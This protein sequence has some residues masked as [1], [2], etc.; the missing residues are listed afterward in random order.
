[1][2]DNQLCKRLGNLKWEFTDLGN[3]YLGSKVDV[4]MCVCVCESVYESVGQMVVQGYSAIFSVMIV[5]LALK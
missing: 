4:T 5:R 3:Q 2:L 1:M